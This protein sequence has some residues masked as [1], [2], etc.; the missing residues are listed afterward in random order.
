M[1]DFRLGRLKFKWR[2]DWA[3]SYAYV[4]D[5][6]GYLVA[7]LNKEYDHTTQGPK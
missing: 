5:D 4:I 7:R 1:A 3:A 2:G 6:D